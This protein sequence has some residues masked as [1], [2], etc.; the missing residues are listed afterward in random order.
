MRN[1][2]G[3]VE[4]NAADV[5]A[6]TS[7]AEVQ[8]VVAASPRIRALGTGHSFNDLADTTGIHVTVAG[9]PA[10]V[11]VDTGARQA[12][13][14]AGLRYGEMA[15]LLDAEG[16]AVHNLA[17]LGH[18][19]VAGTIATGT[20]G[21][22]DRN[23]TLSAAV[24]GLEV[25]T[26]GGDLVTVSPP[27]H[28]DTFDGWVVS[29]GALGVV[30]AVHLAV[31][32]AFAVRQYVFDDVSHAA[33]LDAF[34]ATFASAYSVSFFT[35][36]APDLAGQVWM[37]RRADTDGPW[38]G[39]TLLDG[40]PADAKRHPLPGHDAVNCT[41]QQGQAGPWH[42]RLPHFRL[43]FTPSSGDE[44]QTEYLV[45]RDQ[46]VALLRELEDAGPAHPPAAARVG[47]PH[48]GRRWPVAQRRLRPRHGG[49]P[50]HV[51][52]TTRGPR[53]SSPTWTPSSRNAAAARTGASSTTCR[54]AP[55]SSATRASATSPPWSA[56][57]TRPARSAIARSTR[58]CRPS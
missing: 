6:P 16:W 40:R 28:P 35:C 18:I 24:R 56:M 41:E 43:D 50:L 15:R 19:S 57:S 26:A 2:S 51:A 54:H 3:H 36:W 48:D 44:L 55:S 1:W 37:K 46:A 27:T 53:R 42:E 14:S 12:R 31:E 23:A 47:D 52:A 22:G 21:S 32:P 20:H 58:S 9:L 29:L 5:V 13:V 8:R 17:S 25:V 33:L 11:D 38:P 7:V 34:D 30:T 39:G 4:F 45:P 10:V 49:H